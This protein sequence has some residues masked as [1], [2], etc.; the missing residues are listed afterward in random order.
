[1]ICA[2]NMGRG[3]IKEILRSVFVK[4]SPSQDVWNDNVGEKK[5]NLCLGVGGE[6]GGGKGTIE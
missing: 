5:I 6:K 1:M 3:T 2:G 4:S